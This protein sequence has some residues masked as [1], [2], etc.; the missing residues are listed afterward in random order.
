MRLYRRD[1]NY[2]IVSN[3]VGACLLMVSLECPVVFRMQQCFLYS[4]A[5]LHCEQAHCGRMTGTD[6]SLTVLNSLA[7]GG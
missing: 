4:C 1:N 6:S 7:W 3:I 2:N 5:R